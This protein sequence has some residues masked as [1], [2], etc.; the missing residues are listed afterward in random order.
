MSNGAISLLI[1]LLI[2]FKGKILHL[3]RKY[4]HSLGQHNLIFIIVSA[5][6][7]MSGVG[8]GAN[9]CIAVESVAISSKKKVSSPRTQETDLRD[10]SSALLLCA[11]LAWAMLYCEDHH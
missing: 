4:N 2:K 8:E 6:G 3:N 10:L 1:P 9:Q 7:R 11:V 5:D